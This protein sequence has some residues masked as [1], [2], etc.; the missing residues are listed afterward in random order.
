MALADIA[1]P[2]PPEAAA[3]RS[4]AG[5]AWQ[6]TVVDPMRSHFCTTAPTVP[7]HTRELQKLALQDLMRLH[8][9]MWAPTRVRGKGA[10]RCDSCAWLMW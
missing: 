7:L 10:W 6:V 9:S 2:A 1:P 8:A 5:L 4:D 3:P